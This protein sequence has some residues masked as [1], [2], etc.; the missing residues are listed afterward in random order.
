LATVSEAPAIR[1]LPGFTSC[2]RAFEEEFDYL[3]RAVRRLGVTG[4]DAEDLVQD[5]FVVMWRRW[6]D[7]QQDRPLRPWMVGIA[8]HLAHRHKR[9]RLREVLGARLDTAD[10]RPLA[11]ERL[12]SAATRALVLRVLAELPAKHRIPLVLHEIEGVSIAEIVRLLDIPMAT[13]Y[14]RVRRARLAFTAALGRLQIA[15]TDAP[16]DPTALLAAERAPVPAPAEARHRAV[17]RARALL[18]APPLPPPAPRWPLAGAAA[19][20]LA[21]LLAVG[22]G[23]G[24]TRG[25]AASAAPPPAPGLVGHWRF[26]HPAAA[27]RDLSPSHNDCRVRPHG[28]GSEW[29]SG[30]LVL[31]PDRSLECSRPAVALEPGAAM[32][33]AAWIRPLQLRK[34]HG[35]LV[36]QQLGDGWAHHFLFAVIGDDLV[37]TSDAWDMY[38][39]HPL[40]ADGRW[41]HVAFTRDGAGRVRL[42]IDGRAVAERAG[43]RLTSGRIGRLVVGSTRVDPE[44][45]HI[46]QQFHGAM[47]ELLIF[48]RALPDAELAVLARP[49][50]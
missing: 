43:G 27:V 6:S 8:A 24:R 41:V 9:R 30:P 34:Y 31:G 48:D 37:V 38:L 15:S 23:V 19:L 13:A 7:Y 42:F 4:S 21:A 47:S 39:R 33:A 10:E 36:S 5:V 18:S 17:G 46:R 20:G 16:L 12:A 22:P 1:Q 35:A 40:R 11:E 29:I 32:T 50:G 26:D 28:D 44:W 2:V 25:G 3:H 49:R 14:T 45:R